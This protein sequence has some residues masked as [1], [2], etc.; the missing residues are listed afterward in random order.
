[1]LPFQRVTTMATALDCPK[2]GRSD[3]RPARQEGVLAMLFIA[4]GRVPFRCRSCRYRFF[5]PELKST[6]ERTEEQR[7]VS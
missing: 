1:M 2:C 5:R 7:V 3:T 4:V 6:E